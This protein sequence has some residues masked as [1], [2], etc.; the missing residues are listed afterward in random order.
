M[1]AYTSL[2]QAVLLNGEHRP[3]RTGVGARSLFGC[4]F[5]CDMESQFPLLTSKHVSLKQTFNE[6]KWFLSGST[7]V[8]DLPKAT[9]KWWRPWADA[10]GDLGPTYGRQLRSARSWEAGS[11]GPMSKTIDQFR[12]VVESISADPY[13]RRHILTTWSAADFADMRLP[14][15]HGLV[16]QFYV[17]ENGM[18]S[19]SMYQRSADI[20]IGVPVNIASYAMLLHMVAFAVGR[21]PKSLTITFGDLHLY[22]NHVDQAK[23]QLSRNLRPLPRLTIEAECKYMPLHTIMGLEFENLKL[24]GYD[25]H[26]A[27]EAPVAV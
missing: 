19:L 14:P 26:P 18:I 17:H 22:D 3:N 11:Q 16:I 4:G 8:N 7:N 6:L 5:A 13:S 12:A 10:A 21:K 1:L 23:L 25:P 2:L 15:C 24:E 9:Q 27:I 20:F